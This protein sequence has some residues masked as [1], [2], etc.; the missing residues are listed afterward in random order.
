MGAFGGLILTNTGRALQAKAQAGAT[1]IYTRIGI[2]DGELGG[3]SIPN[4]NALISEKKSLA[5]NKVKTQ[6]GGKAVVGGVLTNQ[7]VETGF[8]FRELGV[9]AQDPDEGEILYC[10]GNAGVNAEYIPA[11]GGPD[12]I[13]KQIDVVTIVGNAANVAATLDESLIHQKVIAQST[14]APATP[15]DGDLWIDTSTTPFGLKRYNQATATWEK[16]GAVTPADIGAETPAGAQA[17][18]DAHAGL[19]NAHSATSAATASRIMMRD[20]AGRAQVAAPSAAADIARKD[21]VDAHA[22]RTDNPH[23]VTAAQVGA[24]AKTG[25]TMTGLLTLS[26]GLSYANGYFVSERTYSVNNT[27]SATLLNRLG[28]PLTPTTTY[29][30]R[31]VTLGTGST[32]GA[33]ACFFGGGTNFSLYSMYSEGTSNCPEFFLDAGVPKVKLIS[34]T[35]LYTISVLCEELQRGKAVPGIHL[36][37][38]AG[39][40][41]Y[42]NNLIWHAGNDGAGSGLD[43][44]MVDGQHASA[45]APNLGIASQAEAEAGTANNLYMTPLRTKNAVD[46]HATRT[47]NPHAVTKAQVGLGSV[48]NY[49]IAT[50]AQAQTGTDNN[51]YMTPLRVKEAIEALGTIANTVEAADYVNTS[52]ATNTWY[53]VVNVNGKGVI[54]RAVGKNRGSVTDNENVQIRV[55]IDGV[56]KTFNVPS[57]SSGRGGGSI[58][59]YFWGTKFDTNLKVEVMQ[60]NTEGDDLECIVDYGLV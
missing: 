37:D 35:T 47:D 21:T 7:D 54:Y 31:G 25:D 20:A 9:F 23:A 26:A 44:D 32:T 1:L 22:N 8:Y 17:K 52:S 3:Q 49:G 39:K 29:V 4:L 51:V 40:L 55:T 46:V 42:K 33:V 59:E 11:G 60:T 13:E 43:A 38:V 41:K 36:S 5:I 18:V 6:P 15:S 30:V 12:I 10:Y 53:V 28:N 45:F 2:G 48:Q 16:V 27:T 24:V 50:Q 56:E 58:L 14:T 34:H 57:G 19:T